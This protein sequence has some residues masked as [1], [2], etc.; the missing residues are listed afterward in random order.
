M[1]R[2]PPPLTRLLLFSYSF[3]VSP[4]S[5]VVRAVPDLAVDHAALLPTRLRHVR[6]PRRHDHNVSPA[7]AIELSIN[8]RRWIWVRCRFSACCE[9][10]HHRRCCKS[11]VSCARRT[12]P[13]NAWLAKRLKTVQSDLM[14]VS[15]ADRCDCGLSLGA[16]SLLCALRSSSP[17]ADRFRCA[18][19][20]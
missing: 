1:A 2:P 6:G 19:S 13:L 15:T 18:R 12:I 8:S 3:F 14:K 16:T 9:L 20:F 7:L 4:R 5:G 10:V 11:I 17:R